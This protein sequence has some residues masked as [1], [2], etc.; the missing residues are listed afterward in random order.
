MLE[1]KIYQ[2]LPNWKANKNKKSLIV[3]GARQVG[4]TYIIDKFCR[5]N[6]N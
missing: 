6:Y 3:K 5:E 2:D 1:R 4:K